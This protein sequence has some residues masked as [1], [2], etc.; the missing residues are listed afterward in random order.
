[1][2]NFEKLLDEYARLVVEFGANV[3]PGK[4]VLIRGSVDAAPFVRKVVKYSYERGADEVV[5]KWN[6]EFVTLE[7]YLNAS[8]KVLGTYEDYKIMETEALYE[9]GATLIAIHTDNPE[10]LRDVDPE[11]IKLAAKTRLN[12][13]KHLMKYTMND[14]VSWTI[15]GVPSAEW[16]EKVYPKLESEAA[17]DKLW[18]EIFKF[19]RVTE[20]GDAVKAWEEHL[21]TMKRHATVLNEKQFVGLKYK[22]DNGTD[23]YVSMPKNH[24][25]HA[26]DAKN[27]EGAR[28]IPNM[29]TEEVFTA[30][31]KFGTHGRLVASM[32]LSHNGKLIKGIDLTFEDGKVVKYSAEE[33]EDALKN[34]LEMDEGAKHLGEVALVPHDS[35]ISNSNTIFYT[36]LFD[37][38]ASCHFALGK[39][40]P[41]SVVGGADLKDEELEGAGLND[42]MI[43]VDFMVGSS[44]LSIIGVEEDGTEFTVFKDGNFAF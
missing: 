31:N 34:M 16:A 39:A 30:P 5:V 10:L 38:N 41:T 8:E 24:I 40:Y 42:S 25:W 36:T 33:N 21:S 43:H 19:V 12:A 44:S 7:T 14:I 13:T 29:P 1:M 28:F 23:L 27:A 32:P 6:D 2:K 3:Q 35:P 26:A 9:R 15:V 17:V 22:S 18:D 4:P 11:R 37:E 20:E